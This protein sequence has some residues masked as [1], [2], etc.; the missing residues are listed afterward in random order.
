MK[1]MAKK[2]EQLRNVTM[3][4]INQKNNQNRTVIKQKQVELKQKE[5][6]PIL[7]LHLYNG[8]YYEDVTSRKA[9]NKPFI[10]SDFKHYIMSID[11]SEFDKSE[12]EL[13][14]IAN[15]ATMMNIA[16]LNYTIDSLKVNYNNEI[17][18]SNRCS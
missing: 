13:Q 1:N 6:S 2:D 11:V 8:N 9:E 14:E 18:S 17:K 5:N 10:K 4:V 15:T 12:E 3:H 7:K 16:Q